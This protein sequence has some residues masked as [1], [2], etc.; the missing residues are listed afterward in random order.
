MLED[1]LVREVER[2]KIFGSVFWIVAALIVGVTACR[3]SRPVN[4]ELNTLT[5]LSMGLKQYSEANNVWPHSQAGA[6]DALVSAIP[7]ASDPTVFPSPRFVVPITFENGE[8]TLTW[9]GYLN[10]GPGELDDDPLIVLAYVA[11]D[12]KLLPSEKKKNPA[13]GN[14]EH[15]AGRFYVVLTSDYLRMYGRLAGDETLSSS[16][17][18]GMK[19]SDFLKHIHNVLSVKNFNKVFGSA[20]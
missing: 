8:A 17:L 16:D 12:Y 7:E 20:N 11:S 3:L 4:A 6:A 10:P 5:F 1:D 19:S 15:Q 18:L 14:M 9:F 13:I 2:W